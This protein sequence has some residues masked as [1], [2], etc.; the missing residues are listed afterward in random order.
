MILTLLSRTLLKKLTIPQ[1][2]HK[3]PELNGTHGF[4]ILF[5]RVQN[6]SS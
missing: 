3:C 5:A 1:L 4:A 6:A 2:V